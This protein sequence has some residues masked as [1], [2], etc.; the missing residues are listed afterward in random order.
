MVAVGRTYTIWVRLNCDQ[1]LGDMTWNAIVHRCEVGMIAL[2][3]VPGPLEGRELNQLSAMYVV[4]KRINM[5]VI[6]H[7][8]KG[9]LMLFNVV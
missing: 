2:V 7:N 6:N 8:V 4:K 9:C 3:V 5:A 1:R